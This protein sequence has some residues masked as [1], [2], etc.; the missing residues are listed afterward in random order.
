LPDYMIPIHF[1]QMESFP[2]TVNGKID[3]KSL[4]KPIRDA[5]SSSNYRK[6]TNSTQQ[7][8][9]QIWQ[10]VLQH[11]KIGIDDNFFSLGG[12]SI[13]AMQIAARLLQHRKKVAVHHLL[14]YPTIAALS[15]YVSE[16][17]ESS[18]QQPITGEIPL[19]P[20]QKYFFEQKFE[21]KHHWNQAIMI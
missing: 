21:D 4:P 10:E 20:I 1:I 14:E 6:P 11:S 8:L 15:E 5:G 2:L 17:N 3:R 18:E 12:D 19:T 9:V 7:L 13:K 16:Q